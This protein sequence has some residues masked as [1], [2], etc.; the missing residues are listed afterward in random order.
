MLDFS[1]PNIGEKQLKGGKFYFG[2]WLQSFCPMVPFQG[3]FVEAV[4]HGGKVWRVTAAYLTATRKKRGE[5]TG[6]TL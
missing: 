3:A 4:H 1:R 2:P 5:E 6:G